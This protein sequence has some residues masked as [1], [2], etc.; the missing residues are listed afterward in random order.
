M[1]LS[2][3]LEACNRTILK[4]HKADFKYIEGILDRW[5]QNGVHTLQDVERADLAYAQNKS[6]T[7]KTT[8][9]HP[10]NRAKNQ[11]Q[12]FQQRSTSTQ[13]VDDLERKLLMR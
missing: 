6:E 5:Q 8:A 13:E 12:N 1:D 11:F 9:S 4:V 7:K 10:Q 2:V 3:I